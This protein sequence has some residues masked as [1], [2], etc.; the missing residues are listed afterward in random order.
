MKSF[1]KK[2]SAWDVFALSFWILLTV[3]PV[4]ATLYFSSQDAQT[5]GALSLKILNRLL[6][7]FPF[8]AALGSVDRLHRLIRKLAHF[9][10]YFVL[11]C[12]LRGLFSYQRRVPA[13]LAAIAAGALYAASDE[14]RQRF[15]S[16]RAPSVADVCID[17]CGVA[18]GCL[19]VSLLFF[20]LRKKR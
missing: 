2:F 1:G 7:R 6:S 13:A 10:L 17:A 11:G 4:V 5:S 16:G 12:G 3:L 8:L 20:L 18:V 15:S 19:L 14:F 9:S